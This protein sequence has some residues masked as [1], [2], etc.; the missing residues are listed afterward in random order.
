MGFSKNK[1][2]LKYHFNKFYSNVEVM[3]MKKELRGA[4]L[5]A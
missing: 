1:K 5:A 4:K 2:F 3:C